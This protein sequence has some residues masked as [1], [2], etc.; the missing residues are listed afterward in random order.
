MGTY[1]QTGGTVSTGSASGQLWMANNAGG[2]G[3]VFNLSGGTFNAAGGAVL[4]VRGSYTFTVSGTGVANIATMQ[5]GHTGGTTN[6]PTG[7]II[8]LD[9]G[10]L[11]LTNGFNYQ[12]GTAV[13]NLNGGTLKAGASTTTFWNNSAS[14][15]ATLGAGGG[16]VDSNG[17][18]ITVNQVLG[19]AGALTKTGAGVLTLGG[20]NVYT[21]ATNVNGGGLTVS[22]A[23]TLAGTTALSVA[24]GAEFRHLPAV[25]ATVLTLGTGATMNLASGSIIGQT[26]GSTIAAPG[27]ATVGSGVFLQMS[28]AYVLGNTYNVLTAAGGLDAGTFNLQLMNNTDFSAVLGQSATAVTVTPVSQAPI[29]TAYWKGGLPGGPSV[30]GL[31]GATASNWTLDGAGAPTSVVPGAAANVFFSDTGAV[32]GDQVNMTLGASMAVNSITSTSANPVSLSNTAGQ[33]LTLGGSA[34]AGITVGPAAA[35]SPSTRPSCSPARRP[36]PTTARTR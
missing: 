30:W 3:S 11:Q 24:G 9:G 35:P 12:S 17:F 5:L 10:T 27:A 23:G 26:F 29:S 6:N 13:V 19:G 14:V 25:Q 7:R 2:T 33:T 21:G 8:N 22:G 36:G 4:G 34:G 31:S 28:G 32:A 18:N 1:T 15:T 20:A 16:V